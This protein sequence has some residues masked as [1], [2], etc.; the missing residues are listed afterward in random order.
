MLKFS[1]VIKENSDQKISNIEFLNSENKRR[2]DKSINDNYNNLNKIFT[3]IHE[4]LIPIL[5]KQ[6]GDITTTNDII[7]SN[8]G[9]LSSYINKAQSDKALDKEYC[10]YLYEKIE[11]NKP[12]FVDNYKNFKDTLAEL[13]TKINEL[14]ELVNKDTIEKELND[15]T[16]NIISN[17][18]QWIKQL[19]VK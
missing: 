19:N 8:S 2:L 6:L 12:K 11:E 14:N 16:D 5:D 13:T 7:I 15:L 4:N 3:L 9:I 1:Q 18:P 10:D 17:Y